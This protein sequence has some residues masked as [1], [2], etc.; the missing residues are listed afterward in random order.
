MDNTLAPISSEQRISNR[1]VSPFLRTAVGVGIS[2]TRKVYVSPMKP[3]EKTDNRFDLELPVSDRDLIDLR[4][5]LLQVHGKILVENAN[6]DYVNIASNERCNLACNSLYSLF[7]SVNVVMGKNQET[8]Y[9]P[10]HPHRCYLRQLLELRTKNSPIAQLAGFAYE[11]PAE[12]RVT[13]IDSSIS[14]HDQYMSS[15]VVELLGKLRLLCKTIINI[16]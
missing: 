3:V 10:F 13:I 14:R 11:K 1:L 9:Q 12:G 15:A 7:E 16:F 6:G 2:A 4:G 5:I 8:Y